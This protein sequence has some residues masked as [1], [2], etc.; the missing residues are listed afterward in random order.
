MSFHNRLLLNRAVVTGLDELEVMVLVAD[1]GLTPVATL[2]ERLGGRVRRTDV[3]VGYLRVDLPTPRLLDLVASTDVDA[4]QIAS[5]SRASWYRDGPP[6][7]NAQ[8]HRG[9]EVAAPAEAAPLVPSDPLPILSR[10]G[11]RAPGYT[12]DDDVGIR[13]WMRAHPTYDGRGVTI[14]L[15][16]SGLAAFGDA[17]LQSAKTLDGR[18]VPK[19]A[20]ILN[21]IDPEQ[22]DETRVHLDT[23]GRS[24]G[25]WSRIGAR[26]YVMPRAG[27]Y[28]FGLFTL[29]AGANLVYQFGVIEEEATGAI[30]VDTNGDADFRDETPIA[31]VNERVDVRTLT[32]A[33][34]RPAELRFVMGRGRTRNAVHIYPGVGG[35]QTMTASVAA[36]NESDGSLAHGVAPGARILLVR[37]NT[38]QYRFADLVEGYLEAARAPGVDVLCDSAGITTVPD[39]SADFMG[40]L[41]RRVAAVYHKP[42]IHSASNMQLFLGSAY[43]GDGFSAGGSIGPAAFAALYG[44]GAIASVMVHPTGAAGPSLDGAV[45]PDFLAPMHRVAADVPWAV[46]REPLPKNAPAFRLPPGYQISCCTSASSPYAAGV[47]ALLISGAKQARVPYSLTTLGRAMRLGARFLDDF[48]SIQQGNGVLDVNAA[49]RELTHPANAPRITVSAPIVHP[50]VRYAARQDGQG[51]LEFEGWTSGMTGR[52]ELRF[53]RDTGSPRPV[54]YRLS[55]TGNDGTFAAPAQVTLPLTGAVSVPVTISVASSG[56]HSA[57]LNLHDRTSHRIVFRTQ[58]TIAASERVDPA[59]GSM[60]LTG[61][62]PLM[63]VRPH[64]LQVPAGT[65]AMSVELEVIRGTISAA[66]VPGHG[67]FPNYYQHLYPGTSRQFTRGRYRVMLPHPVPGTWTISLTN[68]STRIE[69]NRA[70]V[71]AAEAEYAVTI[72]LLGAAL[73]VKDARDGTV[74]VEIENMG[75]EIREP[76]LHTSPATVRSYRADFL[77]TGLPNTFAIDVPAEATTLRLQAT[78]A[79]GSPLEMYLYDCS[80]GECFSYSMAFPA[81]RSQ[82]I[83]VRHPGQGRWVAAVNAAPAPV[84]PGGFV[85]DAIVATGPPSRA[86]ARAVAL[87]SGARWA[88]PVVFGAPSGR[89]NVAQATLIELVDAANE[90][91][92]ATHPWDDRPGVPRLRDRPVALATAILT[93]R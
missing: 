68:D 33:R 79:S 40:L 45:K 41:L 24:R 65:G 62:V 19:I 22:P 56:A 35:H 4:Y 16:E 64:Y 86:W 80:S 6:Q 70:L 50:L 34:S 59:T 39:T 18:D 5:L 89:P 49:W 37:A 3:A 30:R 74:T 9:F 21:T 38:P 51:L 14:A 26:T 57:L 8:M 52:R 55:W 78:S 67:L 44:G 15:I 31:D 72:G 83:V 12:A 77:P 10:D 46:A 58:V 11:A 61:T 48:P 2:V 47:A 13:E 36:G 69:P 75:T 91:E 92:E 42:L 66:I 54:T 43:A 7:S 23:P 73:D 87:R 25:S 81:A 32:L 76:E 20:G 84:A 29:P 63:R 53:V 1:G 28:R 93:P 71:S 85:L 82:T 27:A 60:R 90:R 88:E 17:T